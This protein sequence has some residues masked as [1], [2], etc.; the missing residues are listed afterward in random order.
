MTQYIKQL[1]T[2]VIVLLA[3]DAIQ[4]LIHS[5]PRKSAKGSVIFQT[6]RLTVTENEYHI[7]VSEK[8]CNDTKEGKSLEVD[9]DRLFVEP[10][11]RS[12]IVARRSIRFVHFNHRLSNSLSLI[13]LN[14]PS[15]TVLAPALWMFF[16]YTVHVK[17]AWLIEEIFAKTEMTMGDGS[18]RAVRTSQNFKMQSRRRP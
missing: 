7:A 13:P 5:L 16:V 11:Q 4:S 12:R 8:K 3:E 9:Y 14:C 2:H 10:S 18:I 15:G 1:R 6:A 17:I